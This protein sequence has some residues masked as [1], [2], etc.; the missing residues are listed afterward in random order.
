MSPPPPVIYPR[1]N[2]SGGNE[3]NGNLLPKVPGTQCYTQCPQSCSRPSPTHASTRDFLHSRASPGQSLVE[4]LLL[5]P[6]S[7][8]TQGCVCALQESVSQSCVSAGSS[9]VG[10]MV[11]SSKRAYAIPRSAAPRAPAP[12][13][14]HCWLLPPQET[15]KHSSVSVS[16]RSLGPHV[17]KVF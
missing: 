15:L 4:S 7:W 14:V 16:V 17:H 13:A 11:T 8:Y 2:Y 10:L 1:P 9:M 5:S 6:G 12:V 3:D